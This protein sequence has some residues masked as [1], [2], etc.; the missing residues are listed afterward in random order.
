V[1][2]LDEEERL[3]LVERSLEAWNKAFGGPMFHPQPQRIF[4]DAK[5][6]P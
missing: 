6:L 5:T 4:E 3:D 2:S 1:A